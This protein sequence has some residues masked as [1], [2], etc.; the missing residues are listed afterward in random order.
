MEIHLKSTLVN[1][2]L[3]DHL[4]I[5]FF[6]EKGGKKIR[7]LFASIVSNIIQSYSILF[8]SYQTSVLKSA[9]TYGAPWWF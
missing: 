8:L 4:R 2:Q 9:R 1:K 7:Y 5:N 3:I 6:M